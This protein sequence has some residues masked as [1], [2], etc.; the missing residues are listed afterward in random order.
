MSSL[1]C[2][3]ETDISELFTQ[4]FLDESLPTIYCHMKSVLV[5]GA[6]QLTYLYK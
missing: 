1:L 4:Q 3:R 2:R 5:E 6:K